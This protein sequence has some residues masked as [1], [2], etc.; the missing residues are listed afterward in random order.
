[1]LLVLSF[2]LYLFLLLSKEINLHSKLFRVFT[3]HSLN[4]KPLFSMYRKN[5]EMIS[6]V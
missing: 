3:S 5:I 6:K 1:M 4:Y 2:H